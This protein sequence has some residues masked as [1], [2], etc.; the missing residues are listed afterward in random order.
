MI[1]HLFPTV[2]SIVDLTFLRRPL[3]TLGAVSILMRT[4]SVTSSAGSFVMIHIEYRN[5]IIISL[6][7]SIDVAS[8]DISKDVSALEYAAYSRPPRLPV[9]SRSLIDTGFHLS[10][11]ISKTVCLV[12]T[13]YGNKAASR[14]MTVADDLSH[15]ARV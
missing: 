9:S 10:R 14:R 8:H 2:T 3:I 11:R 1:Y 7:A 6:S 4:T 5:Q 12:P 13:F 15:P